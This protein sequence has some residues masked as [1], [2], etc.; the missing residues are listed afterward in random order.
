[1]RQRHQR[2]LALVGLLLICLWTFAVP[3][4]AEED[5]PQ[6][7]AE[8]D[9]TASVGDPVDENG[10]ENFTPD[11][12]VEEEPI[13]PPVDAPTEEP[14]S[15]P[16][17]EEPS[18][19]PPTDE[20]TSVPPTDEP[21]DEPSSQPPTEE[22]TEEPTQEPTETPT[23]EPTQSPDDE[24]EPD[25]GDGDG[26]GEGYGGGYTEP[27]DGDNYTWTGGSTNG[28]TGSTTPV[29]RPTQILGGQTSSSSPSSGATSKPGTTSSHSSNNSSSGG[30]IGGV[31]ASPEPEYVTFARLN[32]RSSSMSLALFYGGV[33]CVA[34]GV[35]GV[36]GL[37]I[38][39]LRR[40]HKDPRDEL[41]EEIVEA[42]NSARMAQT[43]EILEEG[44]EYAPLWEGDSQEQ[45]AQGPAVEEI[46][47]RIQWDEEQDAEA[48]PDDE[49]E[50]PSIFLNSLWETPNDEPSGDSDR[51]VRHRHLSID[52]E[53]FPNDSLK[54]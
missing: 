13:D 18:S 24:P 7:I 49:D 16:S 32:L 46:A 9:V 14:A 29:R 43:G 44:G 53:D 2:L 19:V 27:S 15:D 42:E 25:D 38:V 12:P 48:D 10:G 47:R 26:D 1:M 33:G 52:T 41:Y 11:P 35:V 39:M 6:S 3:A 40:R 50:E 8:P 51:P 31:E 22:P 34:L 28:S 21:T 17:Y 23:E 5:P 30:I 36:A 20:P 37:L 4:L 54:Q 45:A